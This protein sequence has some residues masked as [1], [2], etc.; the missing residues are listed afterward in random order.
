MWMDIAIG[1]IILISFIL[2]YVRGF[3]NTFLH[4]AGWILSLVLSFVWYPKVSA[5]LKEKT[6]FYD[7][8]HARLT[9]RVA[10]EGSD[11]TSQILNGIPEVLKE[12][13]T[14]ATNALAESL[15]N[16]LADVLFSIISFLI[17]AIGIKLIFLF[18]TSL[19]SKR[20]NDGL[21]G[22]FDGVFGAAFGGL[23]GFVLVLILLALLI[24]IMN[25]TSSDFLQNTLNESR[26]AKV[27][28]DSNPL[29][30]MLN[31]FQ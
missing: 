8:M 29:F 4:T 31:R 28:Y 27:L 26:F 16:G 20:S 7:M 30:L 3:M 17:V 21:T 2:G 11:T 15:A 12:A 10:A 25:L 14:A 18:L 1:V 24:P 13:V 22:F 9:E 5:F 6:G 23:K 19:F